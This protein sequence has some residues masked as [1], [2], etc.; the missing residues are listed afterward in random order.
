MYFCKIRTGL[1]DVDLEWLPRVLWG[2]QWRNCTTVLKLNLVAFVSTTFIWIAEFAATNP[3]KTN[4]VKELQS[5]WP[6]CWPAQ[7][8]ENLMEASCPSR[9][10]NRT[11]NKTKRSHFPLEEGKRTSNLEIW[12]CCWGN[13]IS[14]VEGFTCSAACSKAAHCKRSV[15]PCI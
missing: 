1:R 6:D 9:M 15:D 5:F 14:C 7:R 2:S 3:L 11:E 8:R 10:H 12:N 4:A 13:S